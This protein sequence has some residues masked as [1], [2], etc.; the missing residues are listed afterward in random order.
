YYLKEKRKKN[1][2]ET[3]RNYQEYLPNYLPLPHPSPR[4]NIWLRKNPWFE[5]DVIPFLQDTIKSVSH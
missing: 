2:T 1:L 3:V 4:N 5:S